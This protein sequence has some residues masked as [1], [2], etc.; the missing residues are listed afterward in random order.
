MFSEV[1]FSAI[2]ETYRLFPMQTNANDSLMRIRLGSKDPE[3][4]F[5]PEELFCEMSTQ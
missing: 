2:V 5:Y 3:Q 1:P 4:I